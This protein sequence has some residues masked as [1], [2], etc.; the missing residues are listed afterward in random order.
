MEWENRSAYM[1]VKAQPDQVEALWAKAKAWSHALGAWIVTGDW[2]LLVWIDAEDASAMQRLVAEARQWTGVELTSSH[3]VHQGYKNGKMW[4]DKPAGVWMLARG[5]GPLN[6]WEELTGWDGQVS[7]A[8]IPGAWDSMSWVWG[9]DWGQAW[10]RVLEAKK[11]GWETQTL[12]PMKSWW[13]QKV[14]AGC[15]SWK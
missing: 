12:V 15:A 1:F 8:S 3:F 13:N 4:W 9:D 6:R 5:R 2:D 10:N 7:T 14:A 11:Q